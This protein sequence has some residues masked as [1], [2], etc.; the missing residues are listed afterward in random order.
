M[1]KYTPTFTIIY[2]KISLQIIADTVEDAIDT[3]FK[4]MYREHF[5]SVTIKRSTEREY[6]LLVYTNTQVTLYY[7]V[8]V[9]LL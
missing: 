3:Y 7:I 8:K 4:I 6:N 9:D 5:K 2:N 1:Y